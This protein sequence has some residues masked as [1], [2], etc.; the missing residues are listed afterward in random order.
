M[1]GRHPKKPQLTYLG[2]S[3][4][5]GDDIVSPDENPTHVGLLVLTD[6]LRWVPEQGDGWTVPIHLI[7]VETPPLSRRDAGRGIV[8]VLPERGRVSVFG[9]I[10][11][12]VFSSVTHRGG[13]VSPPITSEIRRELIARGA[14]DTS[15]PAPVE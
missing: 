15:R 14:A 5:P 4:L 7:N 2:A 12:G 8:L 6:D 1:T 13:F 10:E 3:V 11:G 9:R